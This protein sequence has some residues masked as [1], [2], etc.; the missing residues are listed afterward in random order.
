MEIFKLLPTQVIEQLVQVVIVYNNEGNE[1]LEAEEIAYLVNVFSIEYKT[2][3]A[4]M[5]TQNKKINDAIK[6]FETSLK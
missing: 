2:K 6:E 5:E 4:K 1:P 3:K